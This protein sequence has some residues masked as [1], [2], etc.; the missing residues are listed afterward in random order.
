[1]L[2]RCS[3][4]GG[5]EVELVLDTNGAR[6]LNE[7][8]EDLHIVEELRDNKVCSGVDL[9]L[10]VLEVLHRII[11][12]AVSFGVGGHADTELRAELGADEA[13]QVDGVSEALVARLPAL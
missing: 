13:H 11:G 2:Y 12:L 3:C 4:V 8:K 7:V 1:M 10:E 9:L 5:C 6:P